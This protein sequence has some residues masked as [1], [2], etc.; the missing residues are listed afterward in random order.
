M[1][2][3]DGVNT[4]AKPIGPG[5]GVGPGAGDLSGGDCVSGRVRSGDDECVGAVTDG[6]CVSA[7]G[8]VDGDADADVSGV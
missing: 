5:V 8:D 7:E 6:V 3:F 2:S 4:A 1:P